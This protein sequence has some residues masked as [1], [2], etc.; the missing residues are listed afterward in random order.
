MRHDEI[1]DD[2]R[3][4]A[5]DF[6]YWFSRFEFALKEAGFLKNKEVGDNAEVGWSGFIAQYRDNY[7]ITSAAQALIDAKPQ[8]QI[9]G[10]TE[11]DFR[12][13]GFNVGAS[14]LER[15]VGLA[16]TVRNNLFHGGKHGSDYWDQPERMRTLLSTT[17]DVLNELASM[18]GVQH[19]YESYY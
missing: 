6:F 9:V 15:V 19:D 1:P 2:L 16:K 7:Q 8:R 10:V 18:A 4:L 5:F 13:V 11:L 3:R 17:I 14:D 12:D